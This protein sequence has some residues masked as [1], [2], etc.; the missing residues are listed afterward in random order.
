[1]RSNQS[2]LEKQPQYDYKKKWSERA[3]LRQT[4]C[5]HDNFEPSPHA[6]RQGPV[7]A[8]GFG[9]RD[10]VSPGPLLFGILPEELQT[11][12]HEY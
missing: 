2:A 1:M 8:P 3:R 6:S 5:H 11:V 10:L 12:M 9:W 4:V 7:C